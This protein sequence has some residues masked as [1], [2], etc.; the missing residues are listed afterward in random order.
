MGSPPLGACRWEHR[1]GNHLP[2]WLF[3]P[4]CLRFVPLFDPFGPDL[5]TGCNPS[6]T[7]LQGSLFGHVFDLLLDACKFFFFCC[8][9]CGFYSS[10]A[11]RT[12]LSVFQ[13]NVQIVN[14]TVALFRSLH[15]CLEEQL[16]PQAFKKTPSVVHILWL[17]VVP[18]VTVVLLEM[19]LILASLELSSFYISFVF[20]FLWKEWSVL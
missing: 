7:T 1:R 6:L 11:C 4:F 16:S 18:L 20:F 13:L 10:F 3:V 17:L 9:C 2:S 5:H 14:N 15:V 12:S 19:A 8:C